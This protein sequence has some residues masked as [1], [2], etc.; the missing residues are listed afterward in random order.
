MTESLSPTRYSQNISTC[1]EGKEKERTCHTK[2]YAV[3]F[4]K[5]TA[6][7]QWPA[8]LLVQS[9]GLAVDLISLSWDKFSVMQCNY[10]Q[11]V[12]RNSQ[13]VLWERENTEM[14][15]WD[16]DLVPRHLQTNRLDHIFIKH[17][18]KHLCYW[19]MRYNICKTYTKE[20]VLPSLSIIRWLVFDWKQSDNKNE[21]KNQIS[22]F[23][24][25]LREI[26]L[27]I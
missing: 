6:V 5:A 21:E 13:N 11:E 8:V 15:E 2:V 10:S 25:V 16:T 24:V 3:V 22:V 23:C 7:S 4:R 1:D 26:I 18:G 27:L 14:D 20:S 12:H 9:T 17:L 19:Y